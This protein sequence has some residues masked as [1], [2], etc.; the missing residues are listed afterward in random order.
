M[1]EVRTVEIKWYVETGWC[2]GGGIG[3]WSG[4]KESV[5]CDTKEE[6]EALRDDWLASGKLDKMHWGEL[7]PKFSYGMFRIRREE[8][9]LKME[10]SGE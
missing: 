2:D 5:A 9:V 1:I 3:R 6:A 4:T 10:A 8:K 7:R